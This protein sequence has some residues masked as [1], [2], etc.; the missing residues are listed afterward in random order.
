MYQKHSL[1]YF[2]TYKLSNDTNNI[3]Y[4]ENRRIIKRKY[5]N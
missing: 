2:I 3:D 5:K 1:F 4:T